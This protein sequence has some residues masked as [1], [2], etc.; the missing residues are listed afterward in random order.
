MCVLFRA[1]RFCRLLSS[2]PWS[3][4]GLCANNDVQ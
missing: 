4:V 2:V 3:V 1:E